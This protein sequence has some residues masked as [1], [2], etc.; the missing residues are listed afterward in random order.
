LARRANDP[1]ALDDAAGAESFGGPDAELGPAVDEAVAGVADVDQELG[2]CIRLETSPRQVGHQC[3]HDPVQAPAT[4]P[5]IGVS[6]SFTASPNRVFHPT[7]A[8]T[9]RLSS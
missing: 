1:R 3:R 6:S 7:N 4:P 9:D 8:Y 2:F 5:I